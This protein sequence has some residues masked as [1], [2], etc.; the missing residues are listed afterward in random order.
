MILLFGDS[1]ARHSC[2][3][4][5]DKDNEYQTTAR[6]K[7]VKNFQPRYGYRHWKFDDV[8]VE[9]QT[10]DWFNSYFKR[11]PVINFAEFGNTNDWIVENIFQ[12]TAG[13][14]NFGQK[15]DLVIFQTDPI[16]IFAPREDFTDKDVVWPKFLAW[17]KQ[18]KFDYE[19]Q[20]F[21][22]LISKI[23]YNFY[24]GINSSVAHAKKHYNVDISV[25]LVGGVSAIHNSISQFPNFNILIPS[26]SE[27]FGY[28]NDTVFES[29]LA[30]HR[31]IGF[32]ASNVSKR[33]RSILL[34]RWNHYDK[35]ITR[36]TNFWADNPQ[37][38]AGRHLTSQ[39]FEILADYIE[40]H[41]ADSQTS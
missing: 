34:N 40:K 24:Q 36:K 25:H 32:W 31:F 11:N 22:A 17:T 21:D 26:V 38:F 30:L 16:R 27:F 33:Q 1:W 10:S 13:I 28:K 14:S 8:F 4:L 7:S 15:L 3:H 29:H 6:F 9:F 19:T 18:Y 5:V 37:Y 23:F 2:C 39:S 41:I 20:L 35:E 12:R